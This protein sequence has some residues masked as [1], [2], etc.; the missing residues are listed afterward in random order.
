MMLIVKITKNFLQ[1]LILFTKN[2]NLI[3][4]FLKFLDKSDIK[5]Y[6]KLKHY[7]LWS[8]VK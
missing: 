5:M 8:R 1:I 7:A 3:G 2:Q 4:I 6:N